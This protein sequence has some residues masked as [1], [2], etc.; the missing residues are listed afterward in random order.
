MNN[1]NFGLFSSPLGYTNCNTQLYYYVND[2]CATQ[3][4]ASQVEM[5]RTQQMCDY[6]SALA[7]TCMNPML[8]YTMSIPEPPR[9]KKVLTWDELYKI[10]FP[11]DP[12]HD[13]TIEA[14]KKIKA[15]YAWLEEYQ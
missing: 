2:C 7:S 6:R 9:R 15:K 10:A 5:L 14:V 13:Y 1:M 3:N 8:N 4:I 11:Y 12:I